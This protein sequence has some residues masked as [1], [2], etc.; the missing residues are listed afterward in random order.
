MLI[1]GFLFAMPGWMLAAEPAALS[2]DDLVNMA[3]TAN[4]R[5]RSAEAQYQAAL[6]QI[7]PAYAPQD[8]Q[9]TFQT[10][11]SP[12]GLVNAQTRSVGI[13]ESFQFP[14]KA[15]LQ[16]DEAHRAA[17]IARLAY[18]AA[19]RDARAQTLTAYYQTQLDSAAISIGAEN[20]AS[21]GQVLQV[22]KV[23]YSASQAAQ[24][25]LIGAELSLAQSSQ[26]VRG[27]QVAEANDEAA[28]NQ[29]LGR[30]PESP[31]GLAGGLE[32]EPLRL[33]LA[34]IKE[35]AL[36]IRQEILEAA[37]TEKNAKTAVRLAWMEALPDFSVSYFRN[38]YPSGSINAAPGVTHDYSA[39][40]GF[41]VPV[42][43]WFKQKEDVQAAS[44]LLEAARQN[45]RSVELQTLTSVVQLYRS[46]N[47]AYQTAQL[48]KDLLIP[49]A[50]QDFRVA[51]V[52]YQ[53]KKVDFLT[54]S[55][56]LQGIYN[57]RINYLTAANQFLAGKV[58]LEQAI[59]APLK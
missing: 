43:F 19:A 11:Q 10:S 54:L 48:N 12:N 40:L 50:S 15:W 49:L 29:A 58:A 17:E 8:P 35:K 59:G 47:L 41:N 36:A 27:S 6:H 18:L 38:S 52:A 9:L 56:A 2:A 1:V 4:P 22:V 23:A 55:N 14:G 28:L 25:D 45:R 51:L 32:L 30:D 26:S 44:H 24:S 3:M 33:S 21:I 34:D 20:T 7:D 42:F 37:L 53:S 39:S 13:S 31:L 46:T 57:A 5:V 16:G